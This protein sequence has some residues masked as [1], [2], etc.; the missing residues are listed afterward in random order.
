MLPYNDYVQ[1]EHYKD[2]LREAR[3]LRLAREG[4]TRDSLTVNIG[5]TLLK[6]GAQLAAPA[7]GE[8]QNVTT[9]AGQTITVCPA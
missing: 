1:R 8:C 6:V 3:Q 2:L 9:N 5:L 7:P 4:A